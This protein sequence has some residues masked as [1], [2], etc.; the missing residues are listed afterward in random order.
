MVRVKC[1]VTQVRHVTPSAERAREPVAPPEN[2]RGVNDRSVPRWV[3]HLQTETS[4]RLAVG[5]TVEVKLE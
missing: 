2:G 1:S 5:D 4:E 3:R